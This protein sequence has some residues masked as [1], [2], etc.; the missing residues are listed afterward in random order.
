MARKVMLTPPGGSTLRPEFIALQLICRKVFDFLQNITATRQ[1]PLQDLK[2]GLD[3]NGP[4]R[5]IS[6]L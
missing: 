1:S 2:E 5:N 3:D 6:M 4:S